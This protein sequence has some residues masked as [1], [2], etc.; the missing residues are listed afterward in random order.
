MSA[1]KHPLATALHQAHKNGDQKTK[2]RVREII[3]LM[4]RL[5]K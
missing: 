3:E 4:R 5:S 1:K 2:E